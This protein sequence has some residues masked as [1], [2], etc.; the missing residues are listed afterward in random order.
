MKAFDH[1]YST[2]PRTN[3]LQELAG[4]L[5]VPVINNGIQLPAAIGNGFVKELII[6][7]GFFVRYYYFT[8]NHDLKFRWVTDSDRNEAMFKLLLDMELTNS[9]DDAEFIDQV[10]MDRS[11]ILYTTDFDRTVLIKK[12]QQVSRLVLMFSKNWLEENY[13]EASEKIITT[14]NLLVQ[15]NK[16]TFIA[17]NMDEGQYLFAKELVTEMKQDHFPLIH[18]KTKSLI[19]INSFLNRVVCRSSNDVNFTHCLHHNEIKKVEDRIK[20]YLDKPLPNLQVLAA[21]FNMSPAT[22][23]RHFK[24]VYGKSIYHYYL[25]KKLELGKTMIAAKSKSISEIAYTLGYN[26]INSFSKAFKKQYGVLPS[27][28]SIYRASL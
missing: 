21:E 17:E 18:V 7:E 26:R 11:A 23:Q 9:G 13:S 6:E 25:E 19:L 22:L 20:E 12:G 16:P 15:Q 28:M 2:D 10:S 3:Y 27:D 1:V 14:V 8:L 5:Q 24:M 4:K